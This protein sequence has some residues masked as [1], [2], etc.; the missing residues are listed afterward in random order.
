MLLPPNYSSHTHCLPL[1][2]ALATNL[3]KAPM[4]RGYMSI[5]HF[6]NQRR[7]SGFTF[8]IAFP[9]SLHLLSEVCLLFV[10]HPYIF[11]FTFTLFVFLSLIY[12]VA[13]T[14]CSSLP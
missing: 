9:K 4:E 5:F 3:E 10:D 6:K 11:T 12:I 1:L 14:F 13:V 7:K 2:M 8:K